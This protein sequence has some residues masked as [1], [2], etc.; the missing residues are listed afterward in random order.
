M[1]VITGNRQLAERA[2][3]LA[4]RARPGSIE[5]KAAAC[6]AVALATTRTLTAARDVLDGWD[7]PP[8]VRAAA[9][10][11]LGDLTNGE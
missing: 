5:R 9:L 6:A 2:R 7:G 1:T 4:D 3:D 10:A 8:D 11:V